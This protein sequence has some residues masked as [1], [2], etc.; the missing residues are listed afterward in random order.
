[1]CEDIFFIML[2]KAQSNHILFVE[3]MAC[4]SAMGRIYNKRGKTHILRVMLPTYI[5]PIYL[6]HSELWTNHYQIT[7]TNYRTYVP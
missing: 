2:K 4:F 1:M 7:Q 6:K 5:C 3:K